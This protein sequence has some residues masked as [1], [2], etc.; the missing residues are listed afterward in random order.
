ML[1]FSEVMAFEH[2]NFTCMFIHAHTCTQLTSGVGVLSVNNT[3]WKKGWNASFKYH[4]LLLSTIIPMF[5]FPFFFFS[6]LSM[7]LHF[8]FLRFSCYWFKYFF[9][10]YFFSL[11]QK[12]YQIW[13]SASQSLSPIYPYSLLV[14]LLASF[15]GTWL[16]L[17]LHHFNSV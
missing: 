7:L 8:L 15:E 14:F 9:W 6:L 11:F 3:C 5:A 4:S 13:H 10:F 17:L 16:K 1:I 2:V 12:N